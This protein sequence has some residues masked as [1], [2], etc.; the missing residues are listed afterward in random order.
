MTEN[1]PGVECKHVIYDPGNPVAAF[2]AEEWIRYVGL[3]TG[4]SV[5][6]VTEPPGDLQG[7]LILAVTDGPLFDSL[8]GVLKQQAATVEFDGFVGGVHDGNVYVVAAKARGLLFGVYDLLENEFGLVFGGPHDGE[9]FV[10]RGRENIVRQPLKSQNPAIEFRI[11]GFHGGTSVDFPEYA[12]DG[13]TNYDKGMWPEGPSGEYPFD[14]LKAIDWLTKRKCSGFQAFC[15]PYLARREELLAEIRK[16]GIVVEFGGHT[17]TYLFSPVFDNNYLEEHPEFYARNAEGEIQPA[18]LCF[19]N[20]SMRAELVRRVLELLDDCPEIDIFDL[21]PS[22]GSAFCKCKGCSQK[23]AEIWLL[24]TTGQVAEAVAERFPGKYLAHLV[25]DFFTRPPENAGKLP[26]NVI[27]Q[28]CDYWDRIQNRPLCDYRQG[29][30]ALKDAEDTKNIMARGCEIRDHRLVCEELEGWREI[31]VNSGLFTYYGDLI[32]KKVITNIVSSIKQDMNYFHA[33]GVKNFTDCLDLPH[34]WM[35]HAL[36]LFSLAELSWDRTGDPEAIIR[37]FAKGTF[38]PGTEDLVSEYFAV[39]DEMQNKPCFLGFN[40]LTLFHRDPKEV[41]HFAGVMERLIQPTQDVFA[42]HL[43]HLARVLDAL[44]AVGNVNR[45][46]VYELRQSTLLL[47]MVCHRNMALYLGHAYAGKGMKEEGLR[48][49]EEA[50]KR[51]AEMWGSKELSER[52]KQR[53]TMRTA[54]PTIAGA[55]RDRLDNVPAGEVG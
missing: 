33:L 24:E 40:P 36:T 21:W 18:N 6:A 45:K 52:F 42:S 5:E 30:Q 26:D 43:A 2:A 47:G 19:A 23:S 16:R 1:A 39:I 51:A 35:S 27:T 7:T 53:E 32:G 38:G 14:W 31:C 11:V 10:P 50:E 8:P 54:W 28:S 4:K 9:E 3:A 13:R 25:Y 44:D 46:A 55:L 29:R 12:R 15:A 22:D 34:M 17:Y 49:L 41:A 48:A 20:T 37:K